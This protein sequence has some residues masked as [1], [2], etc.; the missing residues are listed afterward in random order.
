MGGW[1][2]TPNFRLSEPQLH[3]KLNL[4]CAGCLIGSADL[5][6][7]LSEGAE[8]G[9]QISGLGELDAIEQV[10]GLSPKIESNALGEVDGFLQNHVPIVD[11]GTV[12]V[13]AAEV[14]RA[15]KGRVR[16]QAQIRAGLRER[17]TDRYWRTRGIKVGALWLPGV[18]GVC[19]GEDLVRKAAGESCDAS[20]LPSFKDCA[21]HTLVEVRASAADRELPTIVEHQTLPYIEVRIAALG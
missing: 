3:T 1:A 14:S 6:G 7:G 11:S 2:A 18:S 13:I 20:H 12:E 8:V 5:S 10:I 21:G 4:P 17:I 15:P 19:G 9:G 16:E